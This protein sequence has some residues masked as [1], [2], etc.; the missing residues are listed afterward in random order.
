M[1][2]KILSILTVIAVIT[3]MSTGMCF[4]LGNEALDNTN[5]PVKLTAP[6]ISA[7][8]IDFSV[9]EAITMT[10]TA[11]TTAL[12]I[13]DFVIT[14]HATTGQLQLDKLTATAETGWALAA[15][16]TEFDKL[17]A[18]TKQFSMVTETQDLSAGPKTY[19]GGEKLA[20][21]NDGTITIS[22][23]GKIGTFRTAISAETVAKVVPTLSVY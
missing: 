20:A 3:V 15:D 14:N 7:G 5:V 22:F 16:T 10:S 1:K 13:T 2:K 19:T 23:T 4:A 8:G 6:A 18:D 12:V 11:N 21:P 9:S 17:P